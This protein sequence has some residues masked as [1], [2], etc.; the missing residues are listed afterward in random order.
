M[1]RIWKLPIKLPSWVEV[2]INWQCIT[3]KWLKWQLDY[4]CPKGVEIKMIENEI[5]TS[6]IS[7]EYKNL[8]GLVRTLIDNMVS[9]VTQWYE[10]KLHVLWVWYNAKVQWDKLI[11]NLGYSHP[12]EYKLPTGISATTTKDSK[13]NDIISIT[14][15]DKQKVWE[16]AAKIITFRAPEVYKWKW[17]RYFGQII[18][19]KA[20][21]TSKK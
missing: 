16:V 1:S 5:H 15:I 13:W 10:K 21:K 8:W 18:K 4:T 17:V 3:V 7:D 9:W 11:L 14:W 6:I 20:G 12:I 19:L 2:N